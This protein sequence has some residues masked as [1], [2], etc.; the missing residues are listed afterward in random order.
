VLYQPGDSFVL[1]ALAGLLCTVIAVGSSSLISSTSVF[2][3]ELVAV[4]A[5]AAAAAGLARAFPLPAVRV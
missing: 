4:A 5:A 2:S 1:A 3:S